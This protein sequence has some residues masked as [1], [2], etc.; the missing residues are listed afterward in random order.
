MQIHSTVIIAV[1][2]SWYQRSFDLVVPL[3]NRQLRCKALLK[4]LDQSGKL[5]NPT[6]DDADKIKQKRKAMASFFAIG[7][8]W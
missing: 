8:L 6:S 1:N 2:I 4:R 5:Q 7:I 3:S